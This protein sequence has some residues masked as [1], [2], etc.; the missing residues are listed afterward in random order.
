MIPRPRDNPRGQITSPPFFFMNTKNNTHTLQNFAFC[1]ADET[2]HLIRSTVID[3]EPW[4]VAKDILT[5]LDLDR[6]ALER[7]DPDE[8]GVNSIHTLGGTQ[9]MTVVNESGLYSLI[10]G[11]RKKEARVFRKWVTAE[12]LPA[13]RKTGSYTAPGMDPAS[14]ITALETRLTEHVASI[15]GTLTAIVTGLGQIHDRVHTLESKGRIPQNVRAADLPI[16]QLY[17]E[18][19]YPQYCPPSNLFEISRR[20]G[21][22]TEATRYAIDQHNTYQALLEKA[23]RQL[24]PN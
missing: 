13:I 16:L 15:T 14:R 5:T 2:A 3:G 18:K 20:L 1:K 24:S 4:F 10:M 17:L 9:E 22:T 6:K 8:K 23:K 19:D 12:V 21:T 11:S 7:I